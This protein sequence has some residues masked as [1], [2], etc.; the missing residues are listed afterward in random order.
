MLDAGY[1]FFFVRTLRGM[2]SHSSG[3]QV[4]DSELAWWVEVDP[5]KGSDDLRHKEHAA[6]TSLM[7]HQI[8]VLNIFVF[9]WLYCILYYPHYPKYIQ[10]CIQ[11]YTQSYIQSYTVTYSQSRCSRGLKDGSEFSGKSG[12]HEEVLSKM[13]IQ[14]FFLGG[15]LQCAMSR[16][17]YTAIQW[18]QK[19]SPTIPAFWLRSACSRVKTRPGRSVATPKA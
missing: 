15:V 18:V 3:L 1:M 13:E 10:S 12:W 5:I 11:S 4:A 2:I 9:V 19:P 6:L 14:D 8:Q 16:I 17:W 7:F